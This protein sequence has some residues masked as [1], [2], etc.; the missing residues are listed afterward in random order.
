MNSHIAGL[1]PV[2]FTNSVNQIR[3][4]CYCCSGN[5][6][7]QVRPHSQSQSQSQLKQK[8]PQCFSQCSRSSSSSTTRN[9]TSNNMSKHGAVLLGQVRLFMCR[10]GVQSLRPIELSGLRVTTQRFAA[11][12]SPIN[13]DKQCACVCVCGSASVCVSV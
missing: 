10:S 3:C 6:A 2:F 13:I 9:N 5:L 11:L 7:Q 4:C 12:V 8:E 1:A